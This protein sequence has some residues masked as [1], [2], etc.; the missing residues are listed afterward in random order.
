MGLH[1]GT[2]IMDHFTHGIMKTFT[3]FFD[4]N[5]TVFYT[6]NGCGNITIQ[7]KNKIVDRFDTGILYGSEICT[8]MNEIDEIVRKRYVFRR[9]M[10]R[11]LKSVRDMPVY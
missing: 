3:R 4:K 11:R 8:I 2:Y 1:R 10:I 6:E 7:Y 9:M 5:V